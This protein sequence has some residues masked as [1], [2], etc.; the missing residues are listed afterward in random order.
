[1]C[2][3]FGARLVEANGEDDHVHLLI[4]YPPTVQLSKLVNSLKGVSSRMLRAQRLPAVTKKLW[5]SHLWSSSYF[6]PHAAALRLPSSANTSKTRGA[7]DP[8]LKD[9]VCGAQVNQ[10]TQARRSGRGP[11]PAS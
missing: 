4:E 2:G 6:A 1:V 5:G 9:R 10:F 3:D 8:A 7:P 11:R